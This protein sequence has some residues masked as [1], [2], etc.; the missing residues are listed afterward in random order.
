MFDKTGTL[1]SCKLRVVHVATWTRAVPDLSP[2]G[3]SPKVT[4][5]ARRL[6]RVVASAE[7]AS[8]HP[9]GRTLC[10]HARG[11]GISLSEPENFSASP[12][13]GL[14]CHVDGEAV[15]VG[16]RAW[17]ATHG[18]SL[19]PSHESDL[20]SHEAVGRTCVLVAA[21]GALAGMVA[22]ADTIKPDAA[23]MLRT[24]RHWRIETYLVS[25][26]HGATVGHV[27]AT[28][29]VPSENVFAEVKPPDPATAPPT[30]PVCDTFLIWQ[31][32][33]AE[34]AEKVAQLQM[35]GHVVAMVGDGINDAPALAQVP[36]VCVRVFR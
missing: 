36:W 21:G 33:P 18:I 12:G 5:E 19:R 1:T 10:E 16:N 31:V 14:S 7:S 25:G 26:D 32:K 4:A 11:L 23:P 35:E 29:G 30:A 3:G 2:R 20:A 24:L 22:L 15:L 6:L 13:L 34:K 27:A 28:L 9:I 8:E 17:L